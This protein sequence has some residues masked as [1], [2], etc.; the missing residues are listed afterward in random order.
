MYIPVYHTLPQVQAKSKI[1]AFRPASGETF[2]Q[3]K[4]LPENRL[5]CLNIVIESREMYYSDRF[6]TY[7]PNPIY[8][9]L[10]L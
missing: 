10:N 7:H 4:L 9:L 6:I 8:F 3:F 2:E 5:N 1:L